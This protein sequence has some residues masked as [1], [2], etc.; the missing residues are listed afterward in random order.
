[1]WGMQF[2]WP[3]KAEYRIV[4]VDYARLVAMVAAEGYD[5]REARLGLFDVLNLLPHLLH[6]HLQLNARPRAVGRAGLAAERI[7]LAV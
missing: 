5:V 4:Y 6:Q 3:I 2:L 7:R 1:M